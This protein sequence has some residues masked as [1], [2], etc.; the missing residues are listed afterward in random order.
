MIV[1]KISLYL[2]IFFSLT[3]TSMASFYVSA[4]G[5]TSKLA[6]DNTALKDKF[7]GNTLGFNL[8]YKLLFVAAEVG[9]RK[10]SVDGTVTHNAFSSTAS[11]TDTL[12][13]DIE[14]FMTTIGAR[15]FILL[16]I[17]DIHGGYAFHSIDTEVVLNNTVITENAEFNSI[18]GDD[19]GVYFGIG[20]QAPL[21]FIDI[22]ANMDFFKLTSTGFIETVV[23]VRFFF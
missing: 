10:S 15:V 1:K 19:S 2:L 7:K 23:G 14:S 11:A 3:S 20:V 18:K 12:T 21:P 9:L 8:G 17:L 22:F 16:S 5:G 13:V 4:F 6:A